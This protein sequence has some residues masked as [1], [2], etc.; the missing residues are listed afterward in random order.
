MS[1]LRA[2]RWVLRLA[3]LPAFACP[4]LMAQQ[5]QPAGKLTG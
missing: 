2:V 5:S 1:H 3:I 4:L